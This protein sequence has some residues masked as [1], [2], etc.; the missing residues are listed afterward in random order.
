MSY[1]LGSSKNVGLL[2]RA[3]LG[4]PA[5]RAPLGG[6]ILTPPVISR[7]KDRRGTREAAI[8]RSRREGSYE[9]LKL[10]KKGQVSG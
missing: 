10:S 5:E 9:C 4:Y 6:V 2:T 1:S 7:T 8:E 3:P